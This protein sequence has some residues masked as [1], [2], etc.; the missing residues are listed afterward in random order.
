MTTLKRSHLT[1]A[2][3]NTHTRTRTQSAEAA[4]TN[5]NSWNRARARARSRTLSGPQNTQRLENRWETRSP[6]TTLAHT[7]TQTHMSLSP[8]P[9]MCARYALAHALT[10]SLAHSHKQP[11][12]THT[13]TRPRTHT[14][15]PRAQLT[16]EFSK[17]LF[18]ALHP[19]WHFQNQT[20]IAPNSFAA[21]AE[22]ANQSKIT[23][24]DTEDAT[25]TKPTHGS[26][27][28]TTTQ[29]PE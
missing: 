4:T 28:T 26:T 24:P 14:R 18:T 5:H 13:H 11:I 19:G 22:C 23:Q 10:L 21:P 25:A 17:W 27:T 20:I 12:H 7:H 8:N 1:C 29:A 16:S 2:P 6:A 3:T 9:H 15:A